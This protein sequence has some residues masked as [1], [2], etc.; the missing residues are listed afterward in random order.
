M[1]GMRRGAAVAG[2]KSNWP[3]WDDL[4][5]YGPGTAKQWKRVVRRN[6][7]RQSRREVQEAPCQYPMNWYR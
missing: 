6:R 5:R 3:W 4:H 7:R 1:T 2:T